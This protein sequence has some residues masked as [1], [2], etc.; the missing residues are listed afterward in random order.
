MR[1]LLLF[2]ILGPWNKGVQE[3]QL[4]GKGDHMGWP[5]QLHTT[6]ASYQL[7]YHSGLYS[8]Y[9]RI[10]LVYKK[11]SGQRH[12]SMKENMLC[13]WEALIFI[14]INIHTSKIYL[15]LSQI[16]EWY[17]FLIVKMEKYLSHPIHCF[18]GKIEQII[19]HVSYFLC[20]LSIVHIHKCPYVVVIWCKEIIQNKLCELSLSIN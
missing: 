14:L 17:W 5:S 11:F 13:M 2:F 7:Y 6:Q 15:Q 3:S 18:P 20:Q 12:D 4:W 16:K 10:I 8:I 1:P 19:L 9:K